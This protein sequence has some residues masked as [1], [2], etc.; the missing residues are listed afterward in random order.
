MADGC[1]DPHAD[2]LAG[3]AGRTGR[4]HRCGLPLHA[5]RSPDR[6]P[7][8]KSMHVPGWPG[9]SLHLLARVGT[10]DAHEFVQGLLDGVRPDGRH[11]V[12]RRIRGRD[13]SSWQ[14]PG[15]SASRLRKSRRSGSS[16]R[17]GS[18]TSSCGSGCLNYLRWYVIRLRSEADRRRGSQRSGPCQ[19]HALSVCSW[20]PR[21]SSLSR[22]TGTRSVINGERPGQRF[23]WLHRWVRGG[24][25]PPSRPRGG[26]DRQPLQVRQ[27]HEV[28][29][30]PPCLHTSSKGMPGTST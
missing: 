8:F 28:L 14:R 30:R 18:P 16:G 12:R 27:G 25:A 11:R 1:D 9:I 29:R 7:I 10:R 5:G 21:T 19:V 17:A 20:Q 23:S 15:A 3:P 24:G 26:G 4:R 2:R 13:S 22:S 6:G